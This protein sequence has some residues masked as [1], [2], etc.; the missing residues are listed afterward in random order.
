MGQAVGGDR[1]G[2][3]MGAVVPVPVTVEPDERATYLLTETTGIR[4]SAG[5][6]GVAEWLAGVLRL[7][8]GLPLPVA[9][10]T[11][12]S[13]SSSGQ[14]R[15]IA[16]LLEDGGADGPEGYRLQ[17]TPDG[18]GLRAAAAAGLFA[19]AQTLLQLLP[20]RIE[21]PDV[22]AGP[23]PVAGGRI[24]DRPRFTY[25]GAMLDVTR[26]FFTVQDV[27]RY[28]D[29]I[30]RYKLNHLHLHL[31][32]DQGWRIEIKGWPRLAEVGGAC[33]VGGGPGGHYTQA[34]YRDLVAY[35]AA[36]H[37]TLVPEID[38]PGHTNAAM[39]AYPELHPDGVAPD[40]YTGIQ[41][42][43]SMLRVDGEAT[44]RFVADVLGEL[45]TL[46][47]GPYLHVGGDEVEIL[48]DD[49]YDEFM[50]YAEQ[51]VTDLGKTPIGWHS[52]AVRA[53]PHPGTVI[54]YW[55]LPTPEQAEDRAAVSAAAQRGTKLI[56][57]PG[58]HAYLDMKY[59]EGSRLGLQ[60]AGFVDVAD[61]YDWDPATLLDRVGEDAVVGVE[62]P[63]WTETA[64]SLADLEYLAFP[65]LAAIA[66]LGWSPAA[67]HDWAGFRA[68]LAAHGPRWTARGISFHP[69]PQVPWPR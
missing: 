14:D 36:R 15:G 35:A 51:V 4:A 1:S 10:P 19:G 40:P 28:I 32:D 39:V 33:E 13:G 11:S 58:D 52:A 29:H 54:Q 22:Q 37:V 17:V 66:E 2:V 25:R 62:A 67:T 24:T 21:A 53:K 41:V 31:S 20:A 6:E 46:T 63:L 64:T 59:D 56:M 48:P 9:A 45:A 34:Q 18:V 23:W 49:P 8:T 47:P 27:R 60:W 38:M 7:P 43:F 65:R 3:G 61:A 26:H 12:T 5:A 50:R 16:L 69:S 55:G 30:A 68:R 44:R 57:S 42:G